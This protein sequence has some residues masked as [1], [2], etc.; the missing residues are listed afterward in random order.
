MTVLNESYLKSTFCPHVV[1]GHTA[2]WDYNHSTWNSIL[3]FGKSAFALRACFWCLCHARAHVHLWCHHS[4][5]I[6][7]GRPRPQISN[8]ILTLLT[9][10]FL[11]HLHIT[12]VTSAPGFNYASHDFPSALII[13]NTSQYVGS[14]TLMMWSMKYGSL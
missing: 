7:R 10:R 9:I 5:D 12:A 6:L 1:A 13:T 14:V 4:R 11:W 8:T 3:E 2:F